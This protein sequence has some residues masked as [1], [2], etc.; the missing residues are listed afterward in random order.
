MAAV[1]SQQNSS[2]SD[3]GDRVS[4]QK[5]VRTHQSVLRNFSG[6]NVHFYTADLQHVAN[7]HPSNNTLVHVFMRRAGSNKTH[8]CKM[9]GVCYVVKK[10]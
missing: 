10:L 3:Q 2:S 6:S 9:N 8:S 1:D 7:A 4:R 5:V